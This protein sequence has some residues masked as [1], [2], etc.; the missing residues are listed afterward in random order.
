MAIVL[1][2]VV[3]GDFAGE[4]VIPLC[5]TARR[6]IPTFRTEALKPVLTRTSTRSF[7]LAAP[8]AASRHELRTPSQLQE[9]L[10]F[11]H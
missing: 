7:P 10:H 6:Y 5:V 3:T 11:T 4:F 2:L 1:L 9:L 8:F